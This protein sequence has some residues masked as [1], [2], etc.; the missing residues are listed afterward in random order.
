MSPE[1]TSRN[2]EA[3][4]AP[5]EAIDQASFDFSFTKE[6][7]QRDTKLIVKELFF[8]GIMPRTQKYLLENSFLREPLPQHSEPR[9]WKDQLHFL[10]ISFLCTINIVLRGIA[11]VYLCNNPL[12]GFLICIGLAHTSTQLLVYALVGTICSTLLGSV[13]CMPDSTDITSGLCG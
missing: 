6:S 2:V 12:S 5:T 1:E 4:V 11:Q 13:L 7:L 3:N 8:A 9:S 10:G